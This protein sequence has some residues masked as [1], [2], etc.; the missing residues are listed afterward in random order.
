MSKFQNCQ[1]VHPRLTVCFLTQ[2]MKPIFNNRLTAE[3]MSERSFEVLRWGEYL[4]DLRQSIHCGD[5]LS[6]NVLPTPF[7]PHFNALVIPSLKFIAISRKSNSKAFDQ[8]VSRIFSRNSNYYSNNYN[9]KPHLP[10]I[11]QIAMYLAS[12]F[13]DSESICLKSKSQSLVVTTTI[14]LIF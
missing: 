1:S 5:S 12:K 2:C 10:N 6:K 3:K 11:L 14:L 8:N 9:N 4:N 7:S 13:D